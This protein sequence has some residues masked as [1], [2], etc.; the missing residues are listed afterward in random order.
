VGRQLIPPRGR[1]LPTDGQ[2]LT[3]GLPHRLWT[4]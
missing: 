4:I 3:D 1:Q 2:L